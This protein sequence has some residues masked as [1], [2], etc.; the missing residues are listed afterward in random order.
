MVDWCYLVWLDG[1]VAW[2][3]Y[4]KDAGECALVLELDLCYDRDCDERRETIQHVHIPDRMFGPPQFYLPRDVRRAGL[5]FREG[6][7]PEIGIIC[8]EEYDE[9]DPPRIIR[10]ERK[11]ITI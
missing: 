11:H 4:R 2:V 8:W 10:L 6:R 5:R 3:F 9:N 1:T 7:L